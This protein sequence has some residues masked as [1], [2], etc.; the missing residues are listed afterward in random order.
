MRRRVHVHRR[1]RS[2][3][4]RTVYTWVGHT[5]AYAVTLVATHEESER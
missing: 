2:I 5:P 4:N 3:N 1:L